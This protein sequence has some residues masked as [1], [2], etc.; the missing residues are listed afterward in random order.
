[1]LDESLVLVHLGENKSDFL[2]FMSGEM[3]QRVFKGGLVVDFPHGVGFS[4]VVLDIKDD[5]QDVR[6]GEIF[7]ERPEMLG[8]IAEI[9]FVFLGGEELSE[10]LSGKVDHLKRGGFAG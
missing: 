6:V 7:H 4:A 5:E 3:I 8:D 1:M 2:V 9:S 10:I